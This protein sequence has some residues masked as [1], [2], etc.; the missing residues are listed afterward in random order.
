[1][2][3]DRAALLAG[4]HHT[5]ITNWRERADAGEPMYFEFFE[6]V[7]KAE[8]TLE[9]KLL[10]NILKAGKIERHW[11][12]NMRLL[13][14]LL[15]EKYLRKESVDPQSQSILIAAIARL[16]NGGAFGPECAPNASRP[17]DS[18]SSFTRLVVE[19]DASENGESH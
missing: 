8:A 19:R 5:S 12:A 2:S 9:K 13:E 4:I 17:G 16:N 18:P 1:M 15:P 6:S 10:A 7:K 11:T 3:L 14:S